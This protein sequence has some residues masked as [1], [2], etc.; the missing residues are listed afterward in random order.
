MTAFTVLPAIDLR[1]RQCVRLVQGDPAQAEVFAREP[2]AVASRFVAEGA[3]ALHVVDLDGAF[4]GHPCQLD[5]VADIARAAAVPVQFGGG[6][7]T[8]RDV[9]AAFEAGV[10]RVVLGTRALDPAFFAA[11]L[12]KWGP[13]RLVVGLDARGAEL[14]VAGWQQ[15][16]GLDV[17]AVA[18]R[19]RAAG[20]ERAVYTQ[21][22]RDGMLAGPDLEGIRRIAASGLQVI[23]SGGVTTA[24]DI[25]ALA[26]MCPQGVCGAILGRAL[27]AGRVTLAEALAA[28]AF[29]GGAVSG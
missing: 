17:V 14:A 29:A 22:Q 21:V 1:S 24:E 2:V 25:R 19:L 23:A 3:T 26:A 28:A 9:D 27:Y 7:R 16:T 13:D 15:R 5:L 6:L 11:M 4:A 20:A 18:A 12:D 8:E 10:A